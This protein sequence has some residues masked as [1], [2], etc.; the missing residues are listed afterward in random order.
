MRRRDE[1][2]AVTA[3]AAVVIP[4]L[5]LVAVGLCWLVSL[6][7]AQLR[8]V[9]AARETARSLARSDPD[10]EARALGRQVAPD[11]ASIVVKEVDGLISVTVHAEVEAPGGLFTFPGFEARATVVAAKEVEP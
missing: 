1:T 4:I 7:V 6:G 9:D 11:G 3:E 2:G 8:V 10:E 5:V